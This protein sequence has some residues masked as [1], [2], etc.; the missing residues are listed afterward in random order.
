MTWLCRTRLTFS[1]LP[2]HDTN[3]QFIS[4]LV[5]QSVI[6]ILLC[7]VTQRAPFLPSLFSAVLLC[8]S[9]S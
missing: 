6:K 9:C 4:S 5:L 8:P 1:H 2:T 3:L 7:R